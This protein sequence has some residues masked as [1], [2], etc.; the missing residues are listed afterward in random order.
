MHRGTQRKAEKREAG[1]WILHATTRIGEKGNVTTEGLEKAKR[2]QRGRA[3][4][5]SFRETGKSKA[6]LG[7]GDQNLREDSQPLL[8]LLCLSL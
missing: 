6:G 1:N 2:A 4:T 5:K 8:S 7:H 3:A